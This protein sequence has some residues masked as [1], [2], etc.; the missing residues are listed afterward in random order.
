M[1]YEQAIAMLKGYRAN[2]IGDWCDLFDIAIECIE[3][4]VPKSGN[5]GFA[6]YCECPKCEWIIETI[7]PFNYCLNCGQ[8]I[9]WED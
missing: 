2:V 9:L 6:K 5:V 7:E 1:T 8:A 3:K 4:Q